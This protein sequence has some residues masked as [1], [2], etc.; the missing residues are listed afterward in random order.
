MCKHWLIV[1]YCCHSNLDPE[2]EAV[3]SSWHC[4][5]CKKDSFVSFGQF[6]ESLCEL[7]F[8]QCAKSGVCNSPSKRKVDIFNTFWKLYKYPGNQVQIHNQLKQ[9]LGQECFA[10]DFV[11]DFESIIIRR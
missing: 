9:T 6:K 7:C 4:K 1:C 11:W 3:Y 2:I 8:Q 5:T 10:K